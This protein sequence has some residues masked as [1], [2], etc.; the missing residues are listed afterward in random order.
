M[1]M[2]CGHVNV[3]VTVYADIPWKH[4]LERQMF[5]G[6]LTYF[7]LGLETDETFFD[8]HIHGTTLSR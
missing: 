2:T 4:M 7:E 5:P 6:T 1:L 8:S 3:Y